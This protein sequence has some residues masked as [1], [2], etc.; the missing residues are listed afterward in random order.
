MRE[1]KTDDCWDR[2]GSKAV[3]D[4]GGKRRESV[5]LGDGDDRRCLQKGRRER[6]CVL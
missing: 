4:E 2:E 3:V 1:S 5:E 6:W